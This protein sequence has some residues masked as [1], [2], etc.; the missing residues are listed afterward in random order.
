M[1]RPSVTPLFAG[2]CLDQQ[3]HEI[4]NFPKL[5][6]DTGGHRRSHARCPVN[7]DEIVDEAVE[8]HSLGVA[9]VDTRTASQRLQEFDQVGFLC[10]C[11]IQ[12]EQSIIVIDDREEIRRTAV[13]KIRWMLPESA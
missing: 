1:V 5:I 13:M 12:R 8:R 3:V 11:E 2:F 10:G 7:P 9:E 6:S 4:R